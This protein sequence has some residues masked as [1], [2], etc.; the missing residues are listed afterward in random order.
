MI[1][2][3]KLRETNSIRRTAE[4][5]MLVSSVVVEIRW[6]RRRAGATVDE[7]GAGRRRVLGEVAIGPIG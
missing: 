6:A 4:A 1:E 3:A 7:S 5:M 2:T